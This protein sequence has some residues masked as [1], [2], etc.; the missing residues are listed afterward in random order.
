MINYFKMLN[1]IYDTIT[2]KLLQVVSI[3][4]KWKWENGVLLQESC[5]KEQNENKCSMY[6]FQNQLLN[7]ILILESVCIY[8]INCLISWFD[9]N[10]KV[11][12]SQ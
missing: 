7:S 11:L 2:E 9:Y 1:I 3:L 12:T 6:L 5:V 8:Y 4:A 10:L